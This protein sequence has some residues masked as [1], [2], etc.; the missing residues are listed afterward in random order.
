MHMTQNGVAGNPSRSNSEKGAK[1]LEA[2][3]SALSNLIVDP[4]TWVAANDLR[5]KETGGIPFNH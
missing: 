4:K 5:S 3:A 2:G 1:M